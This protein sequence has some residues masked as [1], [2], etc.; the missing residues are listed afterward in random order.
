M[1]R[2]IQHNFNQDY[3]NWD[4]GSIFENFYNSQA[5]LAMMADQDELEAEVFADRDFIMANELI[6]QARNRA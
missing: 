4:Q 3:S 6:E 2:P 5:V 1:A